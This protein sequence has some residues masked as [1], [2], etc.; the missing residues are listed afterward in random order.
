MRLTK[1]QLQSA[2]RK[3]IARVFAKN[4]LGQ[5]KRDLMDTLVDQGTLRRPVDLSIGST[6][7]PQLY[8]QIKFDMQQYRDHQ[9][10]MDDMVNDTMTSI[11]MIHKQSIVR[12]LNKR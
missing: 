10:Q 3:V 5:F 8:N 4:F 11:S 6:Y 12:E 9:D 2:E 7:V 1:N